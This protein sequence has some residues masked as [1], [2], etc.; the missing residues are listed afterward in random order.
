[1]TDAAE[2]VARGSGSGDPFE[3]FFG[4][5]TAR[6]LRA[7]ASALDPA[8]PIAAAA[9]RF[10]RSW[11]AF[12]APDDAAFSP[13]R[14]LSHDRSTARWSE[15]PCIF[16]GTNGWA[17]KAHAPAAEP[18]AAAGR[19]ARHVERV[20]AAYPGARVVLVIMPEKDYLADRL[21]RRD[22]A[23]DG[24]ERATGALAGHCRAAG[25]PAVHEA[26]FHGMARFQSPADFLYPDSHLPARSTVQAFAFALQAM[27]LDW[28]AVRDRVR[29]ERRPEHCDLAD[30]LAGAG[31]AVQSVLA[32]RLLGT[33]PRLVGG[34]EGLAAPLGDTTE[35]WACDDPVFD[36]RALILG[37]SHSS[38]YAGRKLT[39]LVASSFR[40]TR[41]DWNPCA[42]RAAPPA[43]DA[44]V[45]LLEVSQRF[46]L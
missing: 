17:A 11:P 13:E 29:F 22:P 15:M 41:F 46:A 18:L 40:R 21:F 16:M 30:R 6:E 37:D 19:F 9:N 1:M 35:E 7:W 28:D 36:R 31:P 4:L 8:D 33:T 27:G 23:Y 43:W 10:A 42:V 44:D 26:V 12:E 39:H 5:R 45:V 34:R 38:I 32:P 25:I 3:R 20:A 24:I 14:H 2:R